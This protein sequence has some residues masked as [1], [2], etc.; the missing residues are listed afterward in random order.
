[1]IKKTPF[2]I[3]EVLDENIYY[4]FTDGVKPTIWENDKTPI[5][6]KSIIERK[7]D[8]KTVFPQYAELKKKYN[9]LYAEHEALKKEY[10]KFKSN[11]GK[12]RRKGT[13]KLVPQQ[14]EEVKSLYNAGIS[15]RQIALKFKVDEKT[16]RN[17]LKRDS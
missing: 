16:I 9:K 3:E 17:I 8:N 4:N 6:L 7:I 10:D 13:Y 1:M 2:Q 15:K 12:G 5:T 14:I 11:M